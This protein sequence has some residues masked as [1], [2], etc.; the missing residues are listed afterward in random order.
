MATS[1]PPASPSASSHLTVAVGA[2]GDQQDAER[3]RGTIGSL[4]TPGAA[5]RSVPGPRSHC[6]ACPAPPA[7]PDPHA[8]PAPE[9]PV[10]A[11]PAQIDDH[12]MG[13]RRHRSI[14]VNNSASCDHSGAKPAACD[15]SVNPGSSTCRP[16]L[17][18]PS[19]DKRTS[20]V[21]THPATTARP[22]A[23]QTQIPQAHPRTDCPQR[24]GEHRP[25]V[26]VALGQQHPPIAL[27]RPTPQQG[28][29]VMVTPG[30]RA[31][32][33]NAMTA[34]SPLAPFTASATSPDAAWA[35]SAA[36]RARHR[37][38]RPAHP[39]TPAP[40]RPAPRACTDAGPA[41]SFAASAAGSSLVNTTCTVSPGRSTESGNCPGFSASRPAAHRPS[42]VSC[43]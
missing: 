30:A 15:G 1:Q 36:L 26:R 42:P 35:A 38:V 41:V 8:V 28:Q 27:Q 21:R 23:T 29:R 14:T 7:A 2:L 43:G 18:P 40:H 12:V 4:S 16:S 37:D 9:G 32:P 33:A 34:I 39:S 22:S 10:R 5:S 17:T 13:E 19:S 31:E 11:A 3:G 6:A 25:S 20:C 24:A